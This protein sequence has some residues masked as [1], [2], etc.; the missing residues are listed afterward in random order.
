MSSFSAPVFAALCLARYSPD[1]PVLLGEY[2]PAESYPLLVDGIAHQ[3]LHMETVVY[4]P[5]S[6]ENIP[7]LAA[8][9][10]G[11]FLQN[12]GHRIRGHTAYHGR[13]GIPAAVG[14]LVGQDG[15]DLTV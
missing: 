6:G 3:P 1:G 12:A 9:L 11:H 10:T 7:N 13:Q 15:V 14:G 8:Q 5:G 4:Q 2:L